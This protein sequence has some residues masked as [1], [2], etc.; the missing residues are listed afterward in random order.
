MHEA[1]FHSQNAFITLTYDE[2]NLPYG[3][4]LVHRDYQLFMKR[5][6]RSLAPKSVRFFMCGEYGE[7]GRP[8]YHAILF[9]HDW[10]DKKAWSSNEGK[11]TYTSETLQKLWGKG[12]TT[13]ADVTWS[14]CAYV[15]RYVMKKRTGKEAE[16]HY[17]FLVEDTG[18]I[19]QR[20]PEYTRMSLRP[21][22]GKE[23]YETY[24]SD[25]YPKDFVTHRG[26]K[27]AVP[28]YYDSLLK[29]EDKKTHEEIKEKRKRKAQQLQHDNTLARLQVKEHCAM[30]RIEKLK[31]RL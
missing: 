28:K 13:S 25:C 1:E 20:K 21:A 27:L 14:S 18:E 7:L 3:Y 15:S 6:R 12:F 19:I 16:D 4:D 26:K 9:G 2:E 11:V 10:P 23:W 8:H 24:K 31:R 22:V 17:R 29:K 30:K 5:L